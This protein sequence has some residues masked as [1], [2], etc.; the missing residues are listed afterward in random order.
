[1]I[2]TGKVPT[3]THMNAVWLDQLGNIMSGGDTVSPRGKETRELLH[4]T[5]TVDMRQPVLT[6]PERKL[7]YQFMAAEAYWI[8]SGDNTVDGIAPWNKHIGQFSDDGVTFAGAYGPR[9]NHQLDYVIDKLRED[10]DTRQAGLTI[11]TPNPAPSKDIPCTVAIW[12]QI[13]GT[14]RIRDLNVSV[15]MRSSDVWLGLPYDVFNFSML[16]YLVAATLN[17]TNK[18]GMIVLPNYLNLTAVSSH[19]YAAN[20]E[21]A[22]DVLRSS[23]RH[24]AYRDGHTVPSWMHNDP[25]L[26]MTTL[27]K[28]RDSKPG[29]EIRWWDRGRRV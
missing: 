24:G 27:L 12:F 17:S 21:A 26:T 29:D 23:L 28:L 19:L 2:R 1:M 22:A 15:F 3:Y 7:N 4:S 6:V 9:I 25:Q 18:D 8:L 20:F 10:P 11:W 13:R 16:G 5:V 14:G